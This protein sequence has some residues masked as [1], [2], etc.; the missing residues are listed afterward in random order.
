MAKIISININREYAGAVERT[1]E[2]LDRMEDDVRDC[3]VAPATTGKWKKWSDK[4][5]IGTEF[6]FTE[7]MLRNTGDVHVDLL[8]GLMDKMVEVRKNMKS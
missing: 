2:A 3:M 5:P 6:N 4:Q 8:C 1:V 7:E